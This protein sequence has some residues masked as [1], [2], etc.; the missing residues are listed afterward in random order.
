M[1]KEAIRYLGFG[2]HTVDN[3]T[4]RF[5]RE[6]FQELE[7][8][9]ELKYTYVVLPLT[10]EC[11][12][13]LRLGTLQISSKHLCKNLEGCKAAILFGITL[14]T[15]VD[16][17]IHR[18]EVANIAKAVVFQACAAAWIEKCCDEFQDNLNLQL[19]PRFSPG[20]GDFSITYQK[21][22]LQILDASKKIGL[23]MTDSYMLTPSKSVTAVIGICDK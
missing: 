21:D 1:E 11:E 23:S 22:I 7:Q 12:D 15:E 9:T 19:R 17:F 4:M 18:Y 14:G 20:Y 10:F 13:C 2:K 16:R 8:I 5:I 3:Q 6:A